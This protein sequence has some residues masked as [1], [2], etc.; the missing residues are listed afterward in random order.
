MSKIE[1]LFTIV[2]VF[3]AVFYAVMAFVLIKL[4]TRFEKMRSVICKAVLS[5][6]DSIISMQK[7]VLNLLEQEK[8]LE[9]QYEAIEDCYGIISHSYDQ[10]TEAFHMVSDQHKELLKAWEKIENR[11]SDTYEVLNGLRKSWDETRDQIE[12]ALQPW[13]I[14]SDDI[15]SYEK[16]MNKVNIVNTT[17]EELKQDL[18]RKKEYSELATSH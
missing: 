2:F 18:K 7:T 8:I 11:Y 1:L 15:Q 12:T 9:K 10:M 4:Y 16:L 13:L 5:Q 14:D 3:F 17:E 6:N